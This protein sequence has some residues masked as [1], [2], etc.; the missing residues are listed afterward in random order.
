MWDEATSEKSCN[1][2]HKP[3]MLGLLSH[4]VSEISWVKL[5]HLTHL[6]ILSLEFSTSWF[7]HGKSAS[8]PDKLRSELQCKGREAHLF[9]SFPNK[10]HS[11]NICY[12][13]E[14]SRPA[15]KEKMSAHIEKNVLRGQLYSIYLNNVYSTFLPHT[16]VFMAAYKIKTPI[17][18]QIKYKN[19]KN[20]KTEQPPKDP[21]KIKLSAILNQRGEMGQTMIVGVQVFLWSTVKC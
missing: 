14:K 8:K 10:N 7:F 13:H 4:S 15:T 16:R 1:K 6:W 19:N 17:Q 2:N 11:L 20:N 5:W 3:A 21:I 12:L 18:L 9:H